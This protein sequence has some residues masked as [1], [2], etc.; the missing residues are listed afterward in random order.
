MPKDK[1]KDKVQAHPNVKARAMPSDDDAE[2]ALLACMMMNND[3]A[4]KFIPQLKE[5]DFYS[6]VH[7]AIFHAM[8]NL[9]ESAKSVEFITVVNQ[10]VQDGILDEKTAVDYITRMSDIISSV[11]NAAV[12]FEVVKKNSALREIINIATE[13]ADRAFAY[14]PD[15]NA[16][17]NA[18]SQIYKLCIGQA[19]RDL[20]KITEPLVEVIGDIEERCKNSNAFR[21]VTT[22]FKKL[23]AY[24]GGGLQNSDLIL[25]AGRPG[26]GKTSLAMNIAKNAAFAKNLKA[27]ART[28]NYSVAVFSLEMSSAQLVR[29]MLCSDANVDMYKAVSGTLSKLDWRKLDEASRR[30]ETVNIYIDDTTQITPSEILSK[31]RKM[32]SQVG[33]DLIMIDYLQLMTSGKYS[34]SRVLEIAEMTRTLKVA[35]KE[36]NVPIIVLSQL[37][38]DI[39]KRKESAPMLSD[40]RDSGAIEQDADIILFITHKVKGERENQSQVVIGKNRNGAT[41]NVPMIWHKTNTTFKEMD[42]DD[43]SPSMSSP[44]KAEETQSADNGAEQDVQRESELNPTS[45]IVKSLELKKDKAKKSDKSTQENAEEQSEQEDIKQTTSQPEQEEELIVNDDDDDIL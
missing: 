36:L 37:S 35:A 10:V 43:Y 25:I 4:V 3:A 21:G 38:R 17:A 18:E 9:N 11:A 5:N 12:Y 26:D 45:Q 15:G 42:D 29:R 30:F 22:G 28:P 32:K 40:L 31:C 24:L 6:I 33:L 8:K 13:M 23:D 44:E 7:R 19:R 27:D 39:E 41:G 2:R 14:D 16:V 34:D 1:I 20:V